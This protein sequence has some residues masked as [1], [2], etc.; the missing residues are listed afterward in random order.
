MDVRLKIKQYG[1]LGPAYF[2]PSQKNCWLTFANNLKNEKI[3]LNLV[4]KHSLQLSIL[5][6]ISAVLGLIEISGLRSKVKSLNYFFESP[7]E[8]L[9]LSC[10]ISIVEIQP[11]LL[12]Q[13]SLTIEKSHNNSIL[14]QFQPM[15]VR[16]QRTFRITF[17]VTLYTDK[18]V[19]WDHCP[20][21][22]LSTDT[23]VHWDHC[24]LR[25]LSTE[26]IVHRDHCTLR[27]NKSSRMIGRKM[28][29]QSWKEQQEYAN[30]GTLS[31]KS[32]RW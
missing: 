23:I 29:L 8:K 22:P 12:E 16:M 15:K 5:P 20:L 24:P 1:R 18:I 6:L 4:F 10:A 19:Q 21:R 27:K 9:K 25:P 17:I 32:F 31:Q 13:L 26:T 2:S 3:V 30:Y 14:F 11:V 7:S 28:S